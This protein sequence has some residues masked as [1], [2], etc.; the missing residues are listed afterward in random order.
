MSAGLPQTRSTQ[1]QPQGWTRR[2]TAFGRRLSEAAALYEQLGYD[3]RLEP[4]EVSEAE[5]AAEGSGCQNCFVMAQARTIY[6]RSRP[7]AARMA[8]LQTQNT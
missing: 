4:V 2:F 7:Q 5:A 3:V 6:T 1:L 8:C